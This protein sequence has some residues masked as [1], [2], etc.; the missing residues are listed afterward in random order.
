DGLEQ[1]PVYGEGRATTPAG[2]LGRRATEVE[3][4]VVDPDV[5]D[6]PP[7]CPTHD[8]GVDAVELDAPAGLVVAEG[9]HAEGL[10]VPFHQGAGRDHLAH[11][12]PGAIATAQPAEG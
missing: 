2:D 6:Q 7:H 9:D 1:A 10:G 3:V 4:D 11:V 12:Q 5:V 8:H